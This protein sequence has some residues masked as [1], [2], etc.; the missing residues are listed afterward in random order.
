MEYYSETTE[1]ADSFKSS[2]ES[3]SCKKIDYSNIFGGLI[4]SHCYSTERSSLVLRTNLT[5]SEWLNSRLSENRL[6]HFSCKAVFCSL[7]LQVRK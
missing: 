2:S 7:C 3:T 1:D 4:P 5:K 6:L